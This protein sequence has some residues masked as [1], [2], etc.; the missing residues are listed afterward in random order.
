MKQV[1]EKELF[2]F[3]SSVKLD[4]LEKF[5]ELKSNDGK[6]IIRMDPKSASLMKISKTTG[7]LTLN[8]QIKDFVHPFITWVNLW[9]YLRLSYQNDFDADIR[10]LEIMEK[11]SPLYADQLISDV[12]LFFD[13]FQKPE[14]IQHNKERIK[15]MIEYLWR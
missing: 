12:I 6:L 15:K 9:G 5:H 11:H 3:C 4:D 13:R 8:P 2:D 14:I 1:N 7:I 10:A